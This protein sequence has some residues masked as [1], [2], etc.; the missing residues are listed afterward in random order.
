MASGI[1][2]EARD[3]EI[4]RMNRLLSGGRPADVVALEARNRSNERLISHLNIQIDFLQQKNE[5]VLAELERA[6]DRAKSATVQTLDS[7]E[8]N[9]Q[10]A[11]DLKD[12]DSKA[13]KIQ[14]EK[15]SA[16]RAADHEVVETKIQLERSRNELE[17]LDLENAAIRQEKEELLSECDCLKAQLNSELADRQ[18][19]ECLLDKAQDEKRRLSHRVNKLTSTERELV[20]EI[21]RLKH[22]CSSSTANNKKRNKSPTRSMECYLR[23][24][25]EERDYFKSEVDQL[26][27]V[28]RAKA[29][30]S[31]RSPS[32]CRGTPRQGSPTRSSRQQRSPG[33][34][35]MN[36]S[37]TVGSTAS[38]AVAERKAAAHYEGIVRVLEE[39]RDLYKQQ[40]D[41]L[42]SHCCCVP[43]S[44][45]SSC[46]NVE[47]ERLQRERDDLQNLL[48]KFERHICE[49]QANVKALT[50]E[51]DSLSTLYEETK[52]ELAMTRQELLR[53]PRQTKASLQAQAMLRRLEN[54]REDALT[55]L[56]RVTTERDT[57]HERL[58]IATDTQLADRARLEQRIE[59]LQNTV[60]NVEAE[61][62]SKEDQVK[63]LETMLDNLEVKVKRQATEMIEA[64]DLISQQKSS[65][66]Q[67][68]ILQEQTEHALKDVQKKLSRKE[69]EIDQRQDDLVHLE[70]DMVTV[71][72]DN[73]CARDEI[74]HLRHTIACMDKEKDALQMCVDEKTELNVQLENDISLKNRLIGKL[75]ANVTEVEALLTS[76][77]ENL[78][79]KEREIASLRRQ[80]DSSSEELM[81]VSR[82]R[83]VALRE[84]RRLQDDLSSMMKENQSVNQELQDALNEREQ[85]KNQVQDYLLEVKRIEELL[86]TKEQERSDLL[87]QY[88]HLS[89]EAER[90]ETQAN[91]LESEGS[92]L[93]L[94]LMTLDSENHHL[95]ER[96][97]GLEREIQEPLPFHQNSSPPSFNHPTVCSSTVTS[98]SS[99]RRRCRTR[100]RQSPTWRTPCSTQDEEKHG[101]LQD[102]TASRDLSAQLEATNE[103]MQRQMT[104][105]ILEQESLSTRQDDLRNEAEMLRSQVT[106]EHTLV[107]NLEGILASNREKE[108]QTQLALQEKDAEI[109]LLKDR[110]A[111]SDSKL[112]SQM[113]EIATMRAK[114]VELESESDRLRRQLTNEKFERERTV[115]ELRKHGLNP[116]GEAMSARSMSHT[117]SPDRRSPYSG[118]T[119]LQLVDDMDAPAVST[120]SPQPHTSTTPRTT[121]AVVPR[122][123]STSTTH[124]Q[125]SMSHTD[126]L[127]HKSTSHPN[128]PY[129]VRK[130]EYHVDCKK[131]ASNTLNNRIVTETFG[132]VE[133]QD[134][135]IS[136]GQWSSVGQCHQSHQNWDKYVTNFDLN[137]T[138]R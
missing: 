49:I 35:K 34:Q 47:I 112:D 110:L 69:E 79:V 124:H 125:L 61:K 121:S 2:V 37:G 55:E 25:E 60:K 127:Q 23:S 6:R 105:K 31:Q 87:E 111:L 53:S 123:Q 29:K 65:A 68:R 9:M 92:N 40:L 135:V 11:R 72:N 57:L 58:Q 131:Y 77:K 20:L 81:E 97:Q 1:L 130:M 83:E 19:L 16:I 52:G 84:N 101:L 89:L 132:Q 70:K 128:P 44:Y 122:P 12:A 36:T 95:K 5:E 85:L 43:Q 113:R 98:K 64:Q 41:V 86:S 63:A 129:E 115:Q 117:S 104:A 59:D 46:S 109:H 91:Q 45:S 136:T 54:E 51:R 102:L 71:E 4:E 39:E 99:T 103:S 32:P 42:K 88:R 90:F 120:T 17:N 118:R 134:M 66:N 93:R 133:Y 107:K 94:E 82:A 24:V 18:E 22:R 56:R 50:S 33:K 62:L 13:Y 96:V 30:V 138:V 28:L 80:A 108:F 106:S 76:T 38:P 116:P 75:R 137:V 21:D 8:K 26:N 67:M 15:E 119:L 27:K 73:R 14:H 114:V 100:R 10:L 78:S 74:C 126:R 7:D 3:A 48:A